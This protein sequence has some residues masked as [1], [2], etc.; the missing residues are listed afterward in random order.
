V[1]TEVDVP[2][3]GKV[4]KQY[5]IAGVVA[6]AGI[7]GFAWY[8]RSRTPADPAASDPYADTRT[9]SE[10]PTDKYTNPAPNGSGDS[11][12]GWKAP[13][14]DVEWA[15]AVVEKLS[16]YENGFVSATVGKYLARQVLT[17]D[18]QTLIREAW[19]Q[20][21]HPPGNQ[22][23]VTQTTTPPPPPVTGAELGAAPVVKAIQAKRTSV[24]FGWTPVANATAYKATR[25]PG[26]PYAQFSLPD[27]RTS[28]EWMGLKPN[29]SYSFSVY[30][31][32]SAGQS[33]KS[34]V[35]HV[36]TNK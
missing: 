6:V 11:G 27:L 28:M 13:T 24:V 32:G 7:V 31:F 36:R 23:I 10:L 18:E 22:P 15:Q 3:V 5:A 8:R 29:T 1:S 33:K 34:N 21:G 20:V 12:S 4:K 2:A 9:G 26:P 30:A 35:I 19:A 14:T 25:G 17:T 16:W